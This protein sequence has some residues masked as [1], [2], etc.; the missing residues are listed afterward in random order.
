MEYGFTCHWS[1]HWRRSSDRLKDQRII[2]KHPR[3]CQTGSANWSLGSV[4]KDGILT[5]FWHSLLQ[6]FVAK[7]FVNERRQVAEGQQRGEKKTHIF[8]EEDPSALP[9]GGKRF[10]RVGALVSVL[11]WFQSGAFSDGPTV[12]IVS[13]FV[14]CAAAIRLVVISF[15]IFISFYAQMTIITDHF[16]VVIFPP[17]IC[18]SY[19]AQSTFWFVTKRHCGYFFKCLK[20][21]S[22]FLKV[23]YY[24]P[25]G[26]FWALLSYLGISYVIFSQQM[27]DFGHQAK[28]ECKNVWTR[29][30][31]L[32]F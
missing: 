24:R 30:F 21:F 7:K 18:F 12:W 17:Y 5:V 8:L 32:I 28:S 3:C 27:S 1:R 29:I 11:R 15:S 4:C 31:C 20:I 6:Y 23:W 9:L 25:G 14:V 22:A 26:F 2:S 19:V 13:S 16:V 10:L